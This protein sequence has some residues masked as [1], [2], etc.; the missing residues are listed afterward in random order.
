[1]DADGV[2]VGAEG[3]LREV[4]VP[5]V[6]GCRK[7]A[8]VI[9][10]KILKRHVSDICEGATRVEKAREGRVLA[11]RY[12]YLRAVVGVVSTCR[13]CD[14]P[15]VTWKRMGKQVTILGSH[16]AVCTVRRSVC[17]CVCSFATSAKSERVLCVLPR[18]VSAVGSQLS[19]Q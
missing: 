12:R 14:E 5:G 10:E 2:G 7:R 6:A 15:R 1:V 9:K 11:Y 4:S 19:S 16:Q 3:E 17:V 13:L 18:R 8:P